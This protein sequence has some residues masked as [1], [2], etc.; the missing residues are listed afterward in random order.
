MLYAKMEMS[1]VLLLY[2]LRKRHG[3][4]PPQLPVA[5]HQSFRELRNRHSCQKLAMIFLLLTVVCTLFHIERRVWMN[6]R[7]SHFWEF[8]VKRSFSKRDCFENFRVRKNTFDYL[9][10]KLRPAIGKRNTVL[11]AAIC[12]EQQVAV[13]LWRLV[14]SWSTEQLHICLAS[15]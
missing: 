6:Q 8:I 14:S 7:S 13:C 11:R 10:L 12:V 9:C 2:L 3:I 5:H 15:Q 4:S 1:L